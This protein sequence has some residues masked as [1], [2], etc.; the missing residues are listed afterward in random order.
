[1]FEAYLEVFIEKCSVTT[2]EYGCTYMQ[3]HNDFTINV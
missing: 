1:M 2:L 3:K